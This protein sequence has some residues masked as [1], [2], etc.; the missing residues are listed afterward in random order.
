M[1]FSSP[2]F[3]FLFLPIVLTAYVLLPGIKIRN[4]WLLLMSLVFYAWGQIDFILLLLA[5]TLMNY[6]LGL[7]VDRSKSTANRSTNGSPKSSCDAKSNA[8][9]VN[10]SR[11]WETEM[12]SATTST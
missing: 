9:C 5:S 10:S 4:F 11:L 12:S 6:G 8:R 1:L 2:I 7:W 3:L